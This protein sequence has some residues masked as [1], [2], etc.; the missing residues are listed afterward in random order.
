MGEE[1]SASPL[2]RWALYIKHLIAPLFVRRGLGVFVR[3]R[4]TVTCPEKYDFSRIFKHI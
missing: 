3:T 1:L 4:Q 2:S